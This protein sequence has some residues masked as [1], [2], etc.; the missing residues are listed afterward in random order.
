MSFRQLFSLALIALAILWHF[1]S[2]ALANPLEV[3]GKILTSTGKP[4]VGATVRFLSLGYNRQ[5]PFAQALTTTKADG[6]YYIFV[7][8]SEMKKSRENGHTDILFA[9]KGSEVAIGNL[10]DSRFNQK[11]VKLQPSVPVRF[12]MIDGNGKPVAGIAVVIDTLQTNDGYYNLDSGNA[13]DALWKGFTDQLG[14]ATVSNVPYA[15]SVKFSVDSS[16]YAAINNIEFHNLTP[17]PDVQ[18]VHVGFFGS[19]SGQV[20]YADTNK[21]VAGLDIFSFES[22]P[23]R[24]YNAKTDSNG[25]YSIP[26]AAPGTYAV[27]PTLYGGM[28]EQWAVGQKNGVV[29]APGKTV[30]NVD[31]KLIQG[32]VL[33]GKVTDRKTGKP[34]NNIQINVGTGDSAIGEGVTVHDD[35]TYKIHVAPGNIHVSIW[36]Q[37]GEDIRK[38]VIVADGETKILDFNLDVVPPMRAIHGIVVDSKGVPAPNAKVHIYAQSCPDETSVADAQGKF[39]MDNAKTGDFLIGSS[40]QLASSAPVTVPDGD[41]DIKIVLD[42]PALNAKGKVV[43]QD[44]KPIA[45]ATIYFTAMSRTS[46]NMSFPV[47]ETKSDLKGAYSFVGLWDLFDYDVTA[48]VNGYSDVSRFLGQSEGGA[49]RNGFS[50]D[51][52]IKRLS[53]L[54][55]VL[56]GVVLD[57]N[58][59]PIPN[60]KVTQADSSDQNSVL[61]DSKGRFTLRR[62]PR[63]KGRVWAQKDGYGQGDAG[64]AVSGDTDYEI[65]MYKANPPKP[66]PAGAEKL[67]GRV[68]DN[69]GQPVVGADVRMNMGYAGAAGSENYYLDPVKTDSDGKFEI[70][71]LP[72]QFKYSVNIQANGY[73]SD[74]NYEIK[75]YKSGDAPGP[76]Y[77]LD[78]LDS[79]VSGKVIDSNGNPVAG[80]Y[81]VVNGAMQT[82]DR[83]G[84]DGTFRTPA[85][86]GKK[87]VVEVTAK[88]GEYAEFHTWGGSKDVTIQLIMP[89]HHGDGT[90]AKKLLIDALAQA[91]NSHKGVLIN[92]YSS[93]GMYWSDWPGYKNAQ[94]VLDKYFILLNID[95]YEQNQSWSNIGWQFL[96][97]PLTHKRIGNNGVMV[98]DPFGKL[99]TTPYQQLSTDDSSAMSKYIVAVLKKAAPHMTDSD[100]NFLRDQIKQAID[101]GKKDNNISG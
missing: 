90:P 87:V 85:P 51:F 74:L 59:K 54:D 70:D 101:A 31:F 80:E 98:Y 100:A 68:V 46:V 36:Q 77:V 55:G 94:E 61:T 1:A 23:D 53:K 86:A 28:S 52:P 9:V 65:T 75:T 32:G 63:G 26:R 33:T 62:F 79:F 15:N 34:I 64:D 69:M 44:A 97:D 39:K 18:T 42:V 84:S 8:D 92:Y 10:D 43:D 82:L 78:K 67:S 12:H 81:V 57:E 99:V 91:K 16:K 48:N 13:A 35:G 3:S 29:V 83:S 6:S 38:T 24:S 21:P 60:V 76:D 49:T 2:S 20:V 96:R 17:N 4:A 19:I 71:N 73:F 25:F 40:N 45:G 5:R 66:T 89:K 22:M 56:S 37:F 7:S 72:A 27:S 50:L 14:N 41:S 30:Y 88:S 58:D 47:G 93:R 11:V 95:T